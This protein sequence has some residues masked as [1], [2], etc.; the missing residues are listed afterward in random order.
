MNKLE[1][2]LNKIKNIKL[3][4][5]EKALIRANISDKINGRPLVSPYKFDFSPYV[6]ISNWNR[7]SLMKA[8][9][10]ALLF[11]FIF[12]SSL[13]YASEQSLPGDTL[14]SIK[15]NVKEEIEIKLAST[16]EKKASVEKSHIEKRLDEITTLKESG[17]L[18]EENSA[19]AIEEFK[20]RTEDLHNSIDTLQ[21][22]GKSEEILKITQDLIPTLTDFVEESAPEVVTPESETVEISTMKIGVEEE[23]PLEPVT[24]ESEAIPLSLDIAINSFISIATEEVEKM[25]AQETEVIE[26]VREVNEQEEVKTEVEETEVINIETETPEVSTPEISTGTL[27]TSSTELVNE[28]SLVDFGILNGVVFQNCVTTNENCLGKGS[29]TGTILIYT[30]DKETLV[31]AVDVDEAGQFKTRLVPGNYVVDIRRIGTEKVLGVP[32]VINI[33]KDQNIN[34]E[35]NIFEKDITLNLPLGL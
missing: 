17:D 34:L 2:D 7:F 5:D 15:V 27:P 3:R 20:E 10:F 25:I 28:I 19:I 6:L 35:I 18:T 13:T 8:G 24:E 1:K 32:E 30:K 21:G 29:A 33:E 16:S 11:M 4:E 12:G 23:T 26:E 14:Y 9:S 31:K 22:E